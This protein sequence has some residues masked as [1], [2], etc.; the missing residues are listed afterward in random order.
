M[1]LFYASGDRGDA[2]RRIYSESQFKVGRSRDALE[3]FDL[4]ILFS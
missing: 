1:N 4:K 3:F 2:L